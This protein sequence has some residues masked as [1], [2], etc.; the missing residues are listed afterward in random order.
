M[1]ELTQKSEFQ[2]LASPQSAG[3]PWPAK[4]R[5]ASRVLAPSLRGEKR[6]GSGG[7]AHHRQL[8]RRR[9]LT[10]SRREGKEASAPSHALAAA[11]RLDE[12]LCAFCSGAD[13][14]FDPE[15]Q[16]PLPPPRLPVLSAREFHE[17]LPRDDLT[18]RVPTACPP[19]L[20]PAASSSPFPPLRA[21]VKGYIVPG[22]AVRL[23]TVSTGDS[24][25]DASPVVLVT[26]DVETWA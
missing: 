1:L 14:Y 26:A 8:T 19:P 5:V 22:V 6:G 13:R 20:V 24:G 7:G 23:V 10:G 15:T 17:R 18:C 3:E 11:N 21:P 2:R 12:L 16:R 25:L 4:S 9:Q